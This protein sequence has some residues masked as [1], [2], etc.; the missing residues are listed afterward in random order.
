MGQLRPSRTPRAGSFFSSPVVGLSCRQPN[1]R[2]KECPGFKKLSTAR[3]AKNGQRRAQRKTAPEGWL[4]LCV[5]CPAFHPLEHVLSTRDG[6]LHVVADVV[7]ADDFFEFG[8]MQKLGGKFAG[9]T[10]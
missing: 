3:S 7:F 6:G 8:F 10:E 1:S 5:H 9:T 4:P 2:L